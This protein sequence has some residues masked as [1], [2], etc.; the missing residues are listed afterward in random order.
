MGGLFGLRASCLRHGK[1]LG[2]IA[3][4]MN[5]PVPRLVRYYYDIRHLAVLSRDVH[6]GWHSCPRRIMETCMAK[7]S[8]CGQLTGQLVRCVNVACESVLCSDCVA[9]GSY[10]SGLTWAAATKNPLWVCRRCFRRHPAGT[11]EDTPAKAAVLC[12]PHVDVEMCSVPPSVVL[13]LTTR[14]A[15]MGG[16]RSSP[17]ESSELRAAEAPRMPLQPVCPSDEKEQLLMRLVFVCEV[18]GQ[19]PGPSVTRWCWWSE[20]NK[21]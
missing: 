4:A 8:T 5:V 13:T 17:R 3:K 1:K 14:G 18:D 11:E 10:W 7:C 9:L 20:H 12:L 19:C 21:S 15:W 6:G 16:P 2:V